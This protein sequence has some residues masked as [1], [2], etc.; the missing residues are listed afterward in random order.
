MFRTMI[1]FVALTACVIGCKKKRAEPDTPDIP[2][3]EPVSTRAPAAFTIKLREEQ[4]GDQIAVVKTASNTESLKV[5]GGADP[6]A[7]SQNA[8]DHFEYT[9]TVVDRPPGADRATRATR[10]YKRAERSENGAPAAPMSYVNKTVLIE[11]RDARYSYT[12]NGAPLPEPETRKFRKLYERKDQLK[13]EDFLPGRPVRVNEKWHY[14]HPV[15]KKLGA[16]FEM[17]IDVAKCSG[18]GRLSKT[19]SRNG[20][21]WGTIEIRADLVL[22]GALVPEGATEAL[23]VSGTITLTLTLDTAIDGSAHDGIVKMKV[24]GNIFGKLAAG[25]VELETTIESNGEERRTTVK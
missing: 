19:Y 14:D 1:L 7:R 20:Q 9:E 17:P 24:T 16:D 15:M 13:N 12:V 11:K 21:Q 22:D 23:A 18:G 5:N 10:A 4:K 25:G 6:F 8:A 3:S 2:I